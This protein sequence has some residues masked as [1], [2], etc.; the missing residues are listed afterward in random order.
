MPRSHLPVPSGF[1]LIELLVVITIVAVL[2]GLL[3]PAVS[4]ARGSAQAIVC[5][6]HLRQLGT[7]SIAYN[8]DWDGMQLPCYDSND[9]DAYDSN[10]YSW[11][12]K[13]RTYLGDGR[14]TAFT[15]SADVRVATCPT[16]PRRWGFGHNY[17]GNG[18]VATSGAGMINDLVPLD[19]ILRPAEK[20]LLCDTGATAAGLAFTASTSAGQ[21]TAWKPWVRYGSYVNPEFTTDFRHRRRANVLWVDCHV[22]SR[23]TGDGF[24]TPGSAVSDTAWW[25][26]N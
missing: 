15:S 22:S 21:F 10:Q 13:L 24:V 18:R 14:T 19:Q 5:T 12:A 4:V 25:F 11:I 7:A 20:V 9:T 16:V 6:N 23:T 3:L 1:T 8:A 2:A 26:R 17:A